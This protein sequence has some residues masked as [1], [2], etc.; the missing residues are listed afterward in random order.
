MR[1][2]S[3]WLPGAT[4]AAWGGILLWFF[5]SGRV[6][7]LLHPM[8]RPYVLIAGIVMLLLACSFVLLPAA[9][10]PCAEDEMAGKT[11]G[12]QAWGRVLTFVILLVPICTA[13]AF[14]SDGYGL[15]TVLNRGVV[16]DAQGLVNKTKPTPYVA[17]PLPS[18]DGSQAQAQEAAPSSPMDEIPRSKDG[19]IIV[20]VVDLLYAAQDTGLRADLKN[21]NVELIGQLM[22]DNVSNTSGKRFKLVR[23]FMVC[24]AADARPVAVLVESESKPKG[25]EMSWIKAVGK[26]EFPV[27]NG[28]PVAVLKADKVLPTD[29]PEETMLY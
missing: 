12:R 2:F 21:Q 8:F 23:M 26:V 7:A 3:R 17:P 11:F 20:Q 9:V 18:R 15:S 28:R 22:P 14:S 25:E 5:F 13:A 10:D 19:N 6:Q 27:E 4:L 24:C 16:S 1:V 29:P